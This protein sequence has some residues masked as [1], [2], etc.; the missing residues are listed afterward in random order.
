MKL[1]NDEIPVVDEYKF[2]GI[3]FDKKLT[4]IPHIKKL[5]TK[6]NQALQLLCVVAHTK[7]GADQDTLLELYKTIIQSKLDYGSMI[8]GSARKSYLQTLNTI[9]HQELRLVLFAFPTSPIESL[10][11]KAN[12]PSLKLR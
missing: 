3:T 10:Y 5:R 1:H 9:H 6:C 7:W 12:E 11:V 2:L 4:F 8:Y